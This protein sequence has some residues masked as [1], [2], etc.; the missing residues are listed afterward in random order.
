MHKCAAVHEAMTSVTNAKHKTSE[1]HVELGE[2]RS[3]RDYSDLNTVKAW[4][5]Q[6][7]PFDQ[8][9]TRLRSLS[10]GLTASQSDGVNCHETEKVGEIRPAET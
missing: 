4:F 8:N 5:D 9:E 6:H 1:Q 7:E 3:N 2:S 10:S